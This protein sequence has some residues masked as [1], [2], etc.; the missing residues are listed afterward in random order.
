MGKKTA[1]LTV[2]LALLFTGGGTVGYILLFDRQDNKKESLKES[3][4]LPIE[5]GL[6]KSQQANLGVQNSQKNTVEDQLPKP[7]KFVTYEQFANAESTQ[8]IDINKGTGAEAVRGTKAHVIYTGYLIN[9]KIF[10]Q[11]Q[12]NQNGQ[13]VAFSFTLGGG[14]VIAGWEQGI[15]GMKVGG[16]RRLVIPSQFGYGEQG[17]DPIPPNSMLIFDVELVQVDPP[18]I[19]PGS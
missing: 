3:V 13:L 14:Q 18:E 16:K 2:L 19:V 6:P 7:D 11:S 8:Y 5:A 17:Q 9:G 10:D 15:N 12:I 4:D 1:V